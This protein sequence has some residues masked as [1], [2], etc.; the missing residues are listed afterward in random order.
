MSTTKLII[1]TL[2]GT[3]YL[4]IVEYVWYGMLNNA[5]GEGDAMPNFYWMLLGYALLS[6][7]FCLIYAKGV[8]PGS[9][10]QQGLKFG[11]LAGVLVFLSSNLMWL[12]LN[13]TFPCM[14]VTMMSTIKNSVFAL[15]EMGLLGII[16]ANLSG[17][18]ASAGD[19]GETGRDERSEPAPPPPP[20]TGVSN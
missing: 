7:A 1:C 3:L 18:S 17:L 2:V 19:R 14:E 9:A 13:E 5:G 20:P 6:L 10:T 12:S 4:F 15:V 11:L 8:E 16:V